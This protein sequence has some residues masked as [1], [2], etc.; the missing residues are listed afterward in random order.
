MEL[1]VAV[2]LQYVHQKLVSKAIAL[3]VIITRRDS[4][5]LKHLVLL[6]VIALLIIVMTGYVR[7]VFKLEI[8]VFVKD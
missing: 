4:F 7:L 2:I 3:H 8:L 1:F 6:I 5:A